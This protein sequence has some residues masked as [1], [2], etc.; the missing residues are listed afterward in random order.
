MM[1]RQG[2]AVLFLL[3]SLDASAVEGD[4][5][6]AHEQQF[7]TQHWPDIIPLQGPPPGAYSELETSLAPGDCGVCHPRQYQDWQSSLHSRTMGPGVL[8]QLLEMVQKDP[9]TA[10][11]CWSCHTPNAEQQD[12]LADESGGFRKN[13]AFDPGLQRQGLICAGCHVR[14]H[15]RYGPPRT[16]MPGEAG[17]IDEGLPHDGFTAE[18]AFS[19]SAFCAGCHQF[20]ADDYALNGKLIENTYEEWKASPYPALG[21]QCQTC[22]M[23]ERRHV[24]R[25]IHDPEMVKKGV[26][27]SVALE[28]QSY[29]PGERILARV[30]IAN[31]GTGHYFPTYMTPKIFVRGY[32]VNE[33]GE[34]YPG[35][36]QEAII[37]REATPDLSREIYDTRIPP[38]N[39]LVISYAEVM[40]EA[41]QQLR[42]EIVVHPDH[43][44]T[45][46]YENYLAQGRGG[47]GR[48]YI[49]EALAHTR[50]TPFTLYEQTFPLTPGAETIKL[51]TG[52]PQASPS[53]LSKRPDARHDG[54]KPDWN[55]A[56]IHWYDHD[57]GIA[58][59]AAQDKPILMVFYAEWC[60]TCHAYKKIFYDRRVVEASDGFIMI[61]VN[62]DEEEALNGRYALD[63]DYVPRIYVL[64]AA[65]TLKEDLYA[66]RDYPRYFIRAADPAAFLALMRRGAS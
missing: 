53:L 16:R 60:P 6:T 41:G 8:G 63:G 24:W 1:Y 32:L 9:E 65:G 23:P 59:A 51:P 62:A 7:L 28:R 4:L 37:G 61:R 46:F 39:S 21:I 34:R 64:D 56:A 10:R 25:G 33:K 50:K 43:F 18:T 29:R 45:R 47:K 66:G 55:D 44:Y 11:T 17:K 26:T 13:H 49:E 2:I 12:V 5:L 52:I 40:Q 58:A 31:T 48:A 35:T 57:S 19:K 20:E 54:G 27:I 3:F 36:L 42:V 30:T 22:H 38:G 14:Q 15:R